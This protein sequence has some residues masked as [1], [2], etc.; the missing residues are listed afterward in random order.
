[1]TNRCELMSRFY[2][3]NGDLSKCI[4][5]RTK[6]ISEGLMLFRLIGQEM[7]FANKSSN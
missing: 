1:M 3:P 7:V 2:L 4:M 5:A 6:N